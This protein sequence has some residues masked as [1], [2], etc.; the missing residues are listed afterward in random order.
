MSV[1]S[2]LT[3]SA[4][5]RPLIAKALNKKFSVRTSPECASLCENKFPPFGRAV[6]WRRI[7]KVRKRFQELLFIDHDEMRSGRSEI[8][9]RLVHAHCQLLSEALH[10]SAFSRRVQLDKLWLRASIVWR[11]TDFILSYNSAE[12]K[13]SKSETLPCHCAWLI[14]SRIS[15]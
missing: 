3:S 9:E 6:N 10:F 8:K 5:C 11:A 2:Q 1:I 15:L 13:N 12:L 4:V 14:R 7:F